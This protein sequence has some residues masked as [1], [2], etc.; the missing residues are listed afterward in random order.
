MTTNAER[1][2]Q[3]IR[4]NFVAINTELEELYFTTE[5]PE[6]VD[7][8]GDN[9]KEQLVEEGKAFI[10]D[11]LKEGNTDEGFEPQ[12]DLL[13][14][15]GLYMA[16][17]RRHE[18]TE[19]SRET[20][21]PL[22]EAS[23][24]AMQLGASLGVAPRFASAHLETHNTAINGCYKTFTSLPDEELFVTCNTRAALAYIRVAE[25][26]LHIVPLGVSHPVTPDLLVAAKR[27]LED[28]IT[29]NTELF[30][31]LDI[32][33]FFYCVRPYYKPH[34]VG[35]REYRGANAGDF[36]GINVI[37]LL[38]G[39]CR[40]D[41]TYYSQLLV[42]QFMFMRPEDQLV[43]RDCMRRQSLLD[44]LLEN[45]D[46]HAGEDW[47]QKNTALFLEV[48]EAHGRTALQHHEQLVAKFIERPAASKGLTERP[49]LTASGPP[50]PVLLKSLRK[51]AD[52][53]AAADRDDI[54]TRYQDR[55]RL[56][57]AIA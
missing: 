17:C 50:L 28:V 34:R 12:F 36:A 20:T 55:Q 10:I 21:S 5:N 35:L 14:N 25:A 40:A 51:L 15:V 38:L 18:I 8:I 23:A 13:G 46:E 32:D 45:L 43:L 16:A 31:D 27:A 57:A 24:L 53:R 29:S 37:D 2:D 3:W 26:L 39:L 33:R 11:L 49:G 47:F 1:L 52:L 41:N 30:Q 19:P 4:G 7:G 54:P 22:V 6:I 42:D 56:R 9:L 44:A 48:C